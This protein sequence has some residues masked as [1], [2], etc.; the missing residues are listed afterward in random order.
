[1]NRVLSQCPVCA[2]QLSITEL[3]CFECQTRVSSRFE[4]N[5]LSRLG[6]EQIHFVELFLRS[7][8]NI[9]AVGGALGVSFPTATKRLDAILA[10][11]GWD[12]AIDVI[13]VEPA[14][15]PV[16]DWKETERARIIDQLDRGEIT[17]DEATR[18]IREL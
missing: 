8:G 3:T 11:L 9:S 14:R 7:R 16:P 10:T 6:P 4:S 2:G 18:R 12:E 1:M 13:D 15:E 5:P 17:A